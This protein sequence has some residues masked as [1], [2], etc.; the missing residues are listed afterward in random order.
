RYPL[1]RC[2]TVTETATVITAQRALHEASAAE[3]SSMISYNVQKYL[4]THGAD[5]DLAGSILNVRSSALA[6]KGAFGSTTS[7]DYIFEYVGPPMMTVEIGYTDNYV[8][9]CEDKNLCMLG[10]DVKTCILVCFEESPRFQFPT[11][12]N[13]I[14]A[15]VDAE[16]MQM[17]HEINPRFDKDIASG[18][19]GPIEYRGHKWHAEMKQVFIEVWRAN[20]ERPDRYVS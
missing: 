9:L 8:A 4:A 11:K 12:S 19:Y 7:A 1:L 10:Y 3:L 13:E 17:R 20:R 16:I 14:I 6:I 18:R 5:P 2:N 15:D